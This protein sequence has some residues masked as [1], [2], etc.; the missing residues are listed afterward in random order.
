[1]HVLTSPNEPNYQ[2]KDHMV[3]VIRTKQGRC[4]NPQNIIVIV[5]THMH[6]G[7]VCVDYLLTGSRFVTVV[8]MSEILWVLYDG[9]PG[10]SND[11]G[12]WPSIQGTGAYYPMVNMMKWARRVL[13]TTYHCHWTLRGRKRH[14]ELSVSLLPKMKSRRRSWLS[15]GSVDTSYPVKELGDEDTLSLEM[16]K[17]SKHQKA[18]A[19]I[20]LH[21]DMSRWKK[22]WM[23]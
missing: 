6:I 13:L 7:Q 8:S 17:A 23:P 2:S 3:W 12:I 16:W 18:E 22:C 4:E 20:Y 1:M 15:T 9:D 11:Y 10:H 14:Y 21:K 19:N 5:V